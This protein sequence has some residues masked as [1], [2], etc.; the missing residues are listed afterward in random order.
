MVELVLRILFF[1][2]DT[3]RLDRHLNIKVQDRYLTVATVYLI[4]SSL[5]VM[6][7]GYFYLVV[8]ATPL[9]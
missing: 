3:V 8:I 9:G 1:R 2:W 6:I 7:L 5:K 4:R